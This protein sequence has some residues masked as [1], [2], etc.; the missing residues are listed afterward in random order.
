MPVVSE[1]LTQRLAYELLRLIK[2]ADE[3][4][5]TEGIQRVNDWIAG[6]VEWGFIDADVGDR[7][8]KSWVEEYLNYRRL[9]IS[10]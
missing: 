10:N 1:E 9:W 7:L 6:E 2:L 8:R 4:E 5:R 3:D